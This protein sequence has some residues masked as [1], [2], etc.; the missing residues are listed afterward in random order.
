MK[1]TQTRSDLAALN[2]ASWKEYLDACGYTPIEAN[3][4]ATAGTM[5]AIFA[6]DAAGR[7]QAHHLADMLRK[8][9]A[10]D[11]VVLDPSEEDPAWIVQGKAA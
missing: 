6:D 7:E 8:A 2:L 5:Q 3:A 10:R 11:V 1:T 4:F 9:G